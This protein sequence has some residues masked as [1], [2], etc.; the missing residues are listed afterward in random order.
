MSNIL[1]AS[2]LTGAIQPYTL[3]ARGDCAQV[4]PTLRMK[5]DT[6]LHAPEGRRAMHFHVQTS[7]ELVSVFVCAILATLCCK[8]KQGDHRRTLRFRRGKTNVQI[9]RESLTTWPMPWRNSST[10]R[11]HIRRLLD[12]TMDIPR[13]G[14]ARYSGAVV[15]EQKS[16]QLIRTTSTS[17]WAT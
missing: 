6:L 13:M 7:R 11:A 12:V 10:N 1:L 3:F 5:T 15:S 9:E 2:W 4:T 17:A 14:S 8:V 16:G